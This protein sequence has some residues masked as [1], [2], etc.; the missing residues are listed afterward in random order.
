MMPVYVS[1]NSAAEFHDE[2]E[3]RGSSALFEG[4]CQCYE[5]AVRDDG[6]KQSN[7]KA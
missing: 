6:V 1:S 2:R 4:S 7:E 3:C 5:E